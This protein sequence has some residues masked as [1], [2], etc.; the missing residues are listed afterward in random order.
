[1]EKNLEVSAEALRQM[2]AEE[3]A[4][5]IE[6]RRESY[7]E[8]QSIDEPLKEI[9]YDDIS[10]EPTEEEIDD[11]IFSNPLFDSEL[12]EQLTDP[13]LLGFSA[14]IGRTNKAWLDEFKENISNWANN[15]SWLG[16]D[17]SFLAIAHKFVPQESK[18]WLPGKELISPW[19]TP[20]PSYLLAEK[21]I[22][23][24][25]LLDELHWRDFEK[26]IAHLLEQ[27]GYSVKLTQPTKDGGVDVI[28]TLNDPISGEI[29][30]VWQAKKY[31]QSHKVKLSEVRELSAIREDNR[32][33]KGMMVTTSKLT[34][35]AIEWVKRDYYRLG[36][37]QHDDIKNWILS[38]RR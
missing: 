22:K 31:K 26:L 36:Y 1:M 5:M 10:D 25:R 29:K 8:V 7:Y 3:I 4:P 34:R 27:S 18:I 17:E 32:A 28:A 30:T 24:G 37:K 9:P 33:S 19:G 35:D 11:F 21:L 14:S 20:I 16:G 15:H 6:M 38:T 2:I 12:I 13:G 23:E